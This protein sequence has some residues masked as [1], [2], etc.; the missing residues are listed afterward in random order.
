MVERVRKPIIILLCMAMLFSTTYLAADTSNDVAG[1]PIRN[2]GTAYNVSTPF[3]IN[4]NAAFASMATAKGWPGDGSQS[5]PYIIDNYD[6][7]GTGYR[8]CIFIGNTTCYFTVQNCYLHNATGTFSEPY[9]TLSGLGLYNVRNSLI[10]NN[11]IMYDAEGIYESN[12]GYNTFFNNTIVQNSDGGLYL[13]GSPYNNISFNNC[14][15]NAG[16][17]AMNSGSGYNTV[18]NNTAFS[19]SNTGI[20]VASSS[21]NVIDNNTVSSNHY[22]IYIRFYTSDS[23]NNV[24]FNNIVSSNYYGFY[25][26]TGTAGN[27][28]IYHNDVINNTIQA[29]DYGGCIWNLDYPYG[30][31]NW[32]HYT[33]PDIYSGPNQDQLGSDNIG[34]TPFVIDWDSSDKYPLVIGR[35]PEVIITIPIDNAQDVNPKPRTYTIQFSRAMNISVGTISTNLPGIIWT[36]SA[37]GVWYNGTYSQLQ[38]YTTYY[39]DLTGGDFVDVFGNPLTGDTYKYFTTGNGI[40]SSSP[41][42]INSNVE[43]DNMAAV[44][45]WLGDGNLGNPYF[46]ENYEINGS[47]FGYCIYIGNTTRYFFVQ[48]C[49]LHNASDNSAYYYWDSGLA[50]YNMANGIVVNNTIFENLYGILVTTSYN[51]V[52]YHNNLVNNTNQAIDDR[53]DNWWNSSYP[54]CGNYWSNYVGADYYSGPNQDLPGSDN[55]GDTPYVIDGDSYDRYPLVTSVPKII[56]TVPTDNAVYVSPVPGTYTIQFNKMMNKSCGM[57]Y[58]NLPDVVWTWSA[59]G[60]WFNGTYSQLQN[61]TTYYVDLT[62]GSFI[63]VSGN[64]LAGDTYKIFTTSFG[65]QSQPFRINSNTEFASMAAAK[66]WSGDGSQGSPYLIENYNIDGNGYR[67]CI[68]IGNTSCNFT[69]QSCYLHH[70]SGTFSQPYFSVSGVELYNVQNGFIINNSFY[71]NNYAGIYLYQSN[72]NSMVDNIISSNSYA[73]IYSNSR[74]SLSTGNNISNNFIF[75]NG[76]GMIIRKETYTNTLTFKTIIA[77]NIISLNVNDGIYVDYEYNAQY[78]IK[79]NTCNNNGGNGIYTEMAPWLPKVNKVDLDQ[80]Q[81]LCILNN[82]VINNHL[83]GIDCIGVNS[84]NV[85]NNYVANNSNYGIKYAQNP[86]G[87]HDVNITNNIVINN[88]YGLYI[89]PYGTF[90]KMNI[91]NNVIASNQNGIALYYS[92]ISEVFIFQNSFL[93]NT[94]QAYD[95]LGKGIWNKTYPIGGNFW[96]DYTGIDIK[97][98]PSQSLP[99]ADGF[100]DTPYTNIGGGTSAKDNYPLMATIDGTQYNISLQQGWNLISVPL[101]QANESLNKVL[102]SA[103]KWDV[104]QTYN[105]TD[106]VHWKSNSSFK[107]DSLNDLKTLNH[108]IGFWIHIT[109]PNVILTIYGYIPTSTSIPL[110]A[111]WNLVGYPTLNTTMT[112]G[113]ALWGTGADRVEVC[114]STDPY[115]TKE[116]GPTYVMKPGEGYWVHATYDTTWVVNW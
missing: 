21:N 18:S 4:S 79:N 46:I 43:F 92:T 90:S 69:I 114:D 20:Y 55:V 25:V 99:G 72:N 67:Y 7:N 8:G 62:S 2:E 89:S 104:I 16:G 86:N 91:S 5:T 66:G 87:G 59:N 35:K 95:Q 41:F 3:R 24:I 50:L 26:D 88:S 33:E 94:I 9:F 31:N 15:S 115:R 28:K 83:D 70:A 1:Q 49:S 107:P 81:S 45:G 106:S 57:I 85:S 32:S 84:T 102:T 116:V 54:S 96:S 76:I 56:I 36:W 61:F 51:N 68:Y 48:N 17:I 73:G 75:L 82:T 111:G 109:E 40:F 97:N 93:G 80:L 30:G 65:I 37:S 58:T 14:S 11:I 47:G 38:N 19:N 10:K 60:G 13:T 78:L 105:S 64:P 44:R 23:I 103:G 27:N 29:H 112:V 52:I 113:N 6:I 42:R 39:V 12:A 100:G 22:A 74:N 63:D 108:K 71:L 98:G 101:S 110:Y 53:N 77:N 34:D